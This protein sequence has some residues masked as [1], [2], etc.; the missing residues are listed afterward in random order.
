[1][2]KPY[3]ISFLIFFLLVSGCTQSSSSAEKEDN[4]TNSLNSEK[5]ELVESGFLKFG[6]KTNTAKSSVDLKK[7]LNGGPVKDGIPAIKNTKFTSVEDADQSIKDD[8]N[9]IV[10]GEEEKRFYPYN[11]LVWHEIVNDKI[12]GRPVAITFCPLCG[13]AIVFSREVEGKAL[14]FGVSGLLYQS[15]LLMYDSETESLWSQV[16][17]EAVVGKYTGTKL[18]M[19]NSQIMTFGEFKKKYTNGLVLST[20]TGYGRDY[21]FY[22]YDD[23]ESNEEIYF[24]VDEFDSRL[25]IK[26][27]VYAVPVEGSVAVFPLKKIKNEKAGSVQLDG[28]NLTVKNVEGELKATF[29][30]EEIAGYYAMYFSVAVHNKNVVI[31]KGGN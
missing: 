30:G 8:I 15:N 12:D 25:P 17:G 14:E 24:P 4:K 27:I 20:D 31:W 26:E 22:P 6:L 11:I 9:G 13:S 1:M 7:V 3:L 10:F 5:N 23:Y 21:T 16:R 18:E 2:G 28:K 29:D 19:L